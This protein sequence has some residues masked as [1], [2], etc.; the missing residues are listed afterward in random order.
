MIFNCINLSA[1]IGKVFRICVDFPRSS[2]VGAASGKM[3]NFLSPRQMKSVISTMRDVNCMIAY[4]CARR[5][6]ANES[7]DDEKTCVNFIYSSVGSL[8]L[9]FF[10]RILFRFV[11][12]RHA[13]F[14]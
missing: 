1:Q 4:I 2:T 12:P 13:L 7:L 10:S 3:D 5:R 11:R 14:Q 9:L 8:L 6:K